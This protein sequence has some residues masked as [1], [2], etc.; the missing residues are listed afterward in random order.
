MAGIKTKH[1]EKTLR[2]MVR[3]F[4]NRKNN[5]SSNNCGIMTNPWQRTYCISCTKIYRERTLW[6]NILA[7]LTNWFHLSA[8]TNPHFVRSGTKIDIRHCVKWTFT[9]PKRQRYCKR[10]FNGN[11]RMKKC[12]LHND[13][14]SAVKLTTEQWF[15]L[16]FSIECARNFDVN[17]W[18]NDHWHLHINQK[19]EKTTWGHDMETFS[20]MMTPSNENIF[21]VTG[22]LCGEF[23]GQW[24]GALL[25]SFIC[26][27]I[28]G[29]VNNGEA[30]DMRRHRAHYDV[31]AMTLLILCRGIHRPQAH[32]PQ[33]TGVFS[34][35]SETCL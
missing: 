27:W 25:F 28:Y 21:R 26:A 11:C 32:S 17:R 4:C 22:H 30:G 5:N 3:V 1:Q 8:I 7:L 18:Y 6:V 15:R 19:A 9:I 23:T 12:S 13:L 24:R 10:P 16:W 2:G 14:K 29:W 34:W 33:K 31:I 35:Y 20:T